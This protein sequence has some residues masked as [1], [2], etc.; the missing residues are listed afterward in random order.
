MF[1]KCLRQVLACVALLWAISAGAVTVP[2]LYSAEIKVTRAGAGPD[3]QQVAEGLAQVL[4]KLSG[5]TEVANEPG[6][7]AVL[8]QA[9]SLLRESAYRSSADGEHWLQLHFDPAQ[10]DELL[11]DAGIRGPGQQRP[12]LLLWL[13][14]K[15]AGAAEDYITADHPALQALLVQA[16]RRGLALQLPLLDLQDLQQ[17]PPELLWRQ[18]SDE[19]R[20][21]SQRYAPDAVLAG[22]IWFEAGFWF[23]EFEFGGERRETQRFTPVGELDEQMA[24]VVDTVADS[25]LHVSELAPLDYRPQGLVLQVEGINGQADYLA[26]VDRLRASEGVTAVF[27]ELLSQGRL[28]LRLQLDTS[29]EQLQ[30]TL[31]LDSRLA[32]VGPMDG[33]YMPD[34]GL[35]QYRWQN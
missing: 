8:A 1:I 11:Q 21:A 9:Q 7:S 18:A 20:L 30:E 32:P 4:I 22:R 31:R 34:T 28:R 10:L 13:V 26:L 16:Q 15:Q 6:Y 24:D 5:S 27:P 35:L 3:S 17:L 25:L 29:V 2:G 23:S 19:V 14:V 33:V 12:A